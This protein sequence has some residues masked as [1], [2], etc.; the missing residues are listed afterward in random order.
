MLDLAEIA[1]AGAHHHGVVT[2]LFVVLVNL[3]HGDHARIFVRRELFLV[4]VGFVPI[5]DTADERRD[6]VNA[7]FGAGASLS[8]GEQQ[9]QV[10]VDAFFLQLLRRADALPGRGQFDQD[11]IVADATLAT[12]S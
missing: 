10:T 9:R 6:Q 3:G 1:E 12:V 5:E 8:E 2:V 7:G 4:A 11:T